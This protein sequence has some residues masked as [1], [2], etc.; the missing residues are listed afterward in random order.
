MGDLGFTYPPFAAILLSPLG[1]L[2]WTAAML[3]EISSR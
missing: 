3:A 2:P 1:V